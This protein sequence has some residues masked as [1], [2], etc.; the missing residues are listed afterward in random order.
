ML[1]MR[2]QLIKFMHDIKHLI[3]T[4][5]SGD[6]INML[7]SSGARCHKLEMYGIE[8]QLPCI[9]G[10]LC[11]SPELS[12]Q[13]HA[14]LCTIRGKKWG[15][16][17]HRVSK[18]SKPVMTL[19]MGPMRY[20]KKAPW[21]SLCKSDWLEKAC[22]EHFANASCNIM[23]SASL[24]QVKV[25]P[26]CY[27]LT[28]PR[29]KH[30]RNLCR[31]TLYEAQKWRSVLCTSCKRGISASKW[32]CPCGKRWHLCDF[33]RSEGFSCKS[34]YRKKERPAVNTQLEDHRA[35]KLLR[36]IE[37]LGSSSCNPAIKRKEMHKPIITLPCT[38][39][40]AREFAASSKYMRLHS[41]VS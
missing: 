28:C 38:S 12:A 4:F 26:K 15:E 23:H 13:M 37:P 34:M 27:M 40:M 5:A 35:L 14:C 31:I 3:R 39:D 30:R 25:S 11:M 19:S 20:P 32:L 17:F 29:C 22:L 10:Q 21:T 36:N 16:P 41:A 1:P 6:S 33:H 2:K 8:E 7:R 24:V 18:R 9:Q